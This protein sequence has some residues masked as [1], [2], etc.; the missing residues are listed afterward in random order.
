MKKNSLIP[1]PDYRNFIP[2]NDKRYDGRVA[3]V[4]YRFIPGQPTYLHAGTRVAYKF[5]K[6]TG[7]TRNPNPPP[8]RRNQKEI[9]GDGID[10][11]GN[12]QIDEGCYDKEML[13]DDNQ[14]RDDT[15]GIRID[16]R[17]FGNTPAGHKREYN[18]ASLRPRSWHTLE[19]IGLH[20]A[21]KRMNGCSD[22]GIVTWGI[23]L[24][25]GMKFKSG[26]RQKS[27]KLQS[28]KREVAKYMIY[29]P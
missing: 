15:I 27:G 26:G 21:G 12:N 9:C 17:N 7:T 20:S 1:N 16:G 8:P 29:V 18:L 5:F 3:A 6:Y 10:N 28:K 2:T 24:G 13:V 19:V 11:N 22:D 25:K 4:Q 23:T 14:C